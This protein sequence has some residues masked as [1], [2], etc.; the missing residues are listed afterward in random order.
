M[1]IL[2]QKGRIYQ[3]VKEFVSGK[4]QKIDLYL[5]LSSWAHFNQIC[6]ET[7]VKPFYSDWLMH[8][9]MNQLKDLD[10]VA[11]LTFICIVGDLQIM[12]KK[13][14]NSLGGRIYCHTCS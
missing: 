2:Q 11:F 10:P 6:K 1:N 8:P 7:K 3:I 5:S 13:M 14:N 4:V 12:G 9:Y